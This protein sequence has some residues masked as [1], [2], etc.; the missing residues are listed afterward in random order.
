MGTGSGGEPSELVEQ[1]LELEGD[2]SSKSTEA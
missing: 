2:R 1:N